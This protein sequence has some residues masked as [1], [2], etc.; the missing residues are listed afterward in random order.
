MYTETRNLLQYKYFIQLQER[1]LK[2]VLNDALHNL[3]EPLNKEANLYTHKSHRVY[4][5]KDEYSL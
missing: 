1:I 3:L 5:R 2:D 4:L